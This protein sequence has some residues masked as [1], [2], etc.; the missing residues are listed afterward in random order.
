MARY[1]AGT[2]PARQVKEVW[3]GDE[4]ITALCVECDTDRGWADVIK[5]HNGRIIA[6]P[7]GPTIE[8][9]YGD[10][11]VVLESDDATVTNDARQARP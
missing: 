10:V 11:R 3:I 5:L 2:Q 9:R 7:L 8:R 4:D 1:E 6:G